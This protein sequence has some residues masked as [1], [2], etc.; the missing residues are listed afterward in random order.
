VSNSLYVQTTTLELAS[1]ISQ[2][3]VLHWGVNETGPKLSAIEVLTPSAES[4]ESMELPREFLP[5]VHALKSFLQKGEPIEFPSQYLNWNLLDVSQWSD[6]QRAVYESITRVPF[7]E[8]RTY[9][10]AALRAG[11][12]LAC[13]AVGQALRKNPLPIL[14]P[15]HR[16]VATQGGLGGFMGK[17]ELHEPELLLKQGLLNLEYE[18]RNPVFSFLGDFGNGLGVAFG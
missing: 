3:L 18:Y 5:V 1:S 2:R 16:I 11:K 12:P 13:R 6:F 10:W 17:T 15:C 14:I 9:S 4:I 7:G 8:T